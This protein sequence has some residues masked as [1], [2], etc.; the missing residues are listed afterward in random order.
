MNQKLNIR[1]YVAVA[2]LIGL[3]FGMTGCGCEC[4]ALKGA[5]LTAGGIAAGMTAASQYKEI[6]KIDME[7]EQMRQQQGAADNSQP[8]SASGPR[9]TD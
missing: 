7:M 2:L 5:A 8:S 9:Q 4:V 3:S 1:H 6:Q